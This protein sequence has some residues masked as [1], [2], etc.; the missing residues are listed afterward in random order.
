MMAP[1]L[2]KKSKF[3][4]LGW[5][6]VIALS[7]IASSIII[8]HIIIQ[9]FI[10]DQEIHSRV[11][12]LSGRQRMLSQRI[13][14]CALLLGENTEQKRRPQIFDE[15]KIALS[16]W[17][18]AHQELQ[19]NPPG[20]SGLN[21]KKTETLFDQIKAD[22][23]AMVRAAAN[24]VDQLR[25][26]IHMPPERIRPD[27]DIILDHEK[28]FLEGMDLIV[29]QYENEAKAKVINLKNITLFLLFFSLGVILFE[30]IFIF[31]PS[32]K[33]I[34]NTFKKLLKAQ[35]KSKKMTMELSAL[36][37][38]LEQ[39][40]QDLL[41]ADVVVEDF[42]V[43]AKCDSLG[44]ITYFSNRFVEVMEFER[45]KPENLFTWLKEQGYNV[46]YLQNIQKLVLS[47]KS[48]SGEIK[49][50]NTAGDFVWLKLN[51]I[52]A[53]SD[54]KQVEALMIIGTDETEKKE[55]EAIS[56][57]I[58]RERI[59]KKVKEQ[60]FRSALILEGQEEERKR[61]SRD[62]HD[63]VGQ[64]L[65]A[66]KFNLESI[67]SV[68]SAYEQEKLKTSKILLKNVIREVRRISF[69][70]TP[71][72][73]SDYG[74]V[75]ALNKFSREITK[76]S[77]LQV[78]FENKTGFISRLEGKIENNLYRI[79]QEAVNNAIKYAEAREVKIILS[80]NSRYLNLEIIDDGK[81][82][83]IKK[84]EEKGHL[85]ASGRGIF[86]IRERANFINGQCDIS[87]IKGKGTV[88]SINVPLD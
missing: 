18:D 35:E 54:Q 59:E 6:Y 49:V 85:S 73:L 66:M 15:L 86:N 43:Y 60:Q 48:W 83:D 72:A 77:D 5:Y 75:A 11:I 16:E 4:K 62:M 82:F 20:K 69:N 1:S 14:K 76:I 9:K 51:I 34:R 19:I 87:S 67:H 42:T 64:L 55:A 26:N 47:G 80:H 40:Y 27:I 3:N 24:L 33:G 31:F 7:A 25:E 45:E 52:P 44:N 50:T 23:Q 88:I 8:S 12:N 71:S 36:Y 37:S 81:G 39:S 79:A 2:I 10:S 22:H 38:S 78:I 57:E 68:K 30:I 70:L 65:S 46:E 56:R 41:E 29:A 84:L 53:F 32:A 61:I 21:S 74:I 58:N 28:S 13:S 63:G 17:K